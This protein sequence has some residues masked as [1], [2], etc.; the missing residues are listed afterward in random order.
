[1]FVLET[2][3][4]VIANADIIGNW[5]LYRLNGKIVTEYVKFISGIKILL[6][7]AVPVKTWQ[8]IALRCMNLMRILVLLTNVSFVFKFLISKAM[9]LTFNTNL[10]G[11]KPLINS[12]GYLLMSLSLSQIILLYLWYILC[13]PGIWLSIPVLIKVQ[14]SF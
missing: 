14:P 2:L 13:F 1:M 6:L 9:Q 7:H 12:T 5:V 8:S 4:I 10:C 11:G 3:F